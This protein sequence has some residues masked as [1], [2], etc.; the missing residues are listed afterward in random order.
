MIS[1]RDERIISCLRSNSR[2]TLAAISRK[3]G[4]PVSTV[5]DRIRA[6]DGTLIKKHTCIVDFP[7]LGYNLRFSIL[8][9][10]DKPDRI[11]HYLQ[12]HANVNS[13][14]ALNGTYQ[15]MADCIFRE[16]K[17]VAS[18]LDELKKLDVAK[19]QLHFV[20]DELKREGFMN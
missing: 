18:F 11:Q 4:V 16:M 2:Q 1:K 20:T 12:R 8:L 9:R 19:H 14:F 10:A 13:V 6:Q 17:D 15:L 3:A 5:Y 7:R